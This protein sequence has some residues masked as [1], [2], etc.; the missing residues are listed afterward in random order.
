MIRIG[1]AFAIVACSNASP[2]ISNAAAM[3]HTKRLVAVIR[4]AT[5]QIATQRRP[6]SPF[7]T[8]DRRVVIVAPDEA[9]QLAALGDPEILADLVQLLDDP[10]RA[11]AANAML[12][13]LTAHGED[14]VNAYATEPANWWAAL[15]PRARQSWQAFLAGQRFVWDSQAHVFVAK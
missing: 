9:K 7:A 12:A 1:L 3:N 6:H 14:I 2:A 8:L 13:S 11:W 4:N 10:E 15:G 5:I